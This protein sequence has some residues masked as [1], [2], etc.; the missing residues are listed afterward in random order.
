M[1]WKWASAISWARI[2]ARRCRLQW[3]KR[4]TSRSPKPWDRKNP[5]GPGGHVKLTPE[6]IEQARQRA[7]AAGRS[8]PNLVDNMYVAAL[9]RKR[10]AGKSA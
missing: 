3:R 8:Y 4:I 10:G 1:A 6:Q 7:E 2:D 5:A 9:S